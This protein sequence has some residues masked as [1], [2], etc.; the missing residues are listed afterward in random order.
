MGRR[1]RIHPAV[2]V[3]RVGN[4]PVNAFYIGPEHPDIPANWSDGK[5]QSFRDAEGRIKRQAAR[6]R[7]F[8]Y[9]ED[10]QGQISLPHEVEIGPDV[11]KIE[12]RVHVANK[13]AAFFA[14]FG[15]HGADD[16]YVKRSNTPPDAAID[17]TD[18]IRTN[19]RNPSVPTAERSTRLELDPG[20][21]MISTENPEP[22]V[23][24]H[25]NPLVPFVKDLGE[26]RLDG[27][28]LLFLGGHGDSGSNGQPEVKI[29]EYASND[30][31]FDDVS[32]GSVK[33]RV[34]LSDGTFIDADAAWVTVGPPDFAPGIGNVVT[35]YDT[36]WDLA[37]RE[38]PL[39]KNAEFGTGF[40]ARL[41]EQKALWQA[42]GSLNGYRPSFSL[43]IYPLLVRAFGAF[44]VFDAKESNQSFHVSLA[45]F[46]K[47]ATPDDAP[48]GDLA[49]RLRQTVCAR[50]RD[51]AAEVAD[52]KGMPRG[53][54]D[55]YND[56]DDQV[57]T[58]DPK[59]FLSLTHVQH[60]TL[61]AW[62]SGSFDRL[63]WTGTEPDVPN[64]I[65][66]LTPQDIDRA[67]LVNC[68]G[69]PFYPG[70]EVS[71]LVRRPELYVEPFRLK[72]PTKPESEAGGISDLQI[73]ALRFGPGFFSQQ[74][75]LPWQADFY[76][77]H[78]E[79]VEGP[80]A[81]YTF[82]WWTAQRPDDVLP[83]TATKPSDPRVRWVRQFDAARQTDD[84]DDQANLARFDQMQKNWSTL[85]FVL[86]DKA[87]FKEEE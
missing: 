15:Q 84:P 56:I 41:T 23:L 1:F 61:T 18:P 17:G 44:W 54:G 26:L 37:V 49:K 35:L 62:G 40:L 47:C 80:E 83:S 58:A 66:T 4:A 75:A 57:H 72:V 71:W 10:E 25:G 85:K 53:F 20:E 87:L 43:E 21:K 46:E 45:S 28:R 7:V 27:A 68:V 81:S 11:V 38:L 2:G 69:G 55:Q 13:K 22:I 42:N 74:M 39:P 8:E 82:M 16:V 33:A 73:G 12:W 32:D 6:F 59:S 64:E 30:T 51:P 70:I 52:W 29:D 78:K 48:D 79:H 14:F 34:F 50:L 67:A 5:F 3:A 24:S 31:W 86:G 76:D 65:A 19:L 77:C 60:G 36:M 9:Q 63:G